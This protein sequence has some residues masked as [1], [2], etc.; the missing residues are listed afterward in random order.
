MTEEKGGEEKEMMM[1]P[2][3]AAVL[4]P[5][6]LVQPS[7]GSWVGFSAPCAHGELA[8]GSLGGTQAAVPKTKCILVT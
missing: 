6:L 4:R 1:V 3:V 8:P 2:L 5:A 7:L